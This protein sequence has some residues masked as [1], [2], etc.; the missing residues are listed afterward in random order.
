MDVFPA[1]F[2]ALAQRGGNSAVGGYPYQ[3]KATDLMRNFVH[4]A[5]D[6][7]DDLVETTSGINGY[8]QR[9]LKISAGTSA[10][11]I[12]FWD[13]SKMATLAAPPSGDTYVLGAIGGEIQWIATEEC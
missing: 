5:L 3:I 11:Q 8:S 10:N 6:T 4:A 12:Y 1:N 13:G 7:E 9:K 2:E